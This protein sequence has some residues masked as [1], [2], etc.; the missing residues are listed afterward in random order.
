MDGSRDPSVWTQDIY[1]GS[2][3]IEMGG[4]S[5]GHI[6]DNVHAFGTVLFY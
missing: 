1:G 2:A 5:T 4:S 6:I 3:L